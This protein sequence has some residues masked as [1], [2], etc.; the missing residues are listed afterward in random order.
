MLADFLLTPKQQRIL[1][2]F[3]LNPER[4]YSLTELFEL[5]GGGRSS[6]QDFVAK[7]LAGA[8]IS[9]R[10]GGR[11]LYQANTQH[12][13]YPELR[14]IAVKSFGVKEPIERALAVLGDTISHAFIFGSMAAGTAGPASDIDVMVIGSARPGRVQRE[15]DAAGAALGREIHVNVYP[16]H[17]WEQKRRSDPVLESID[18]GPKIMLD[19]PTVAD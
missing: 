2:A 3:F 18:Q 1:G 15:L 4:D 16:E 10:S 8:V 7:L 17:E 19:V 12:P 13:L 9:Q 5:S 11:A 14:Q 6:T